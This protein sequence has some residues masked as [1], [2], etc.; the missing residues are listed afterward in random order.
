MEYLTLD[1][2]RHALLYL[3]VPAWLLAGLADYLCHRVQ[4]IETSGGLHE[5][6][7]HLAMLA[8]LGAGVLVALL[9]D[10]SAATLWILLAACLLHEL[11]LLADL[12]WAE[13]VRGIPWYEQW[14]H[15]VQQALPWMG[16]AAVM[17]LHPTQALAM[18]GLGDVQPDWLLTRKR[19]PLPAGYLATVVGAAVLLV[20]LPFVE[21]AGRC[22]RVR[23]RERREVPAWKVR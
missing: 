7:L 10:I 6:L 14:V 16:L 20:L 3:L 1:L 2:L 22:L 18:F 12:H 11:I 9:F 21:E 19:A 15:G 17:L 13:A 5:S 4:H 23:W 8:A